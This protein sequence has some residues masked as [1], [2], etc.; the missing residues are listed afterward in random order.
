MQTMERLR[1]LDHVMEDLVAK[2]FDVLV[3][4][5]ASFLTL[6]YSADLLTG[7]EETKTG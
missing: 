6:Q 4:E 1:R 3:V 5:V 2:A 7:L